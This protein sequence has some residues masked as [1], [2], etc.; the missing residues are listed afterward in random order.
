MLEVLTTEHKKILIDLNAVTMAIEH[1]GY[2]E[3][4]IDG[5]PFPVNILCNLKQLDNAIQYSCGTLTHSL[6]PGSSNKSNEDY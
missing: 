5:I 3:L 2:V 6:L 4:H 1:E